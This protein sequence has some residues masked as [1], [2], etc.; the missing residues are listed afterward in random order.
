VMGDC[1]SAFCANAGKAYVSEETFIHFNRILMVSV[2]FTCD[3]TVVSVVVV[4]TRCFAVC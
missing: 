4:V 1:F 3:V 2:G